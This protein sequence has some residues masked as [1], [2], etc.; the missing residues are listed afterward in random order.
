MIIRVTIWVIGDINLLSPP[1]PP[2][3]WFKHQGAGEAVG[4][5]SVEAA[6]ASAAKGRAKGHPGYRA[7]TKMGFKV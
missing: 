7:F 4:R 2:S 6:A 1:D 3:S 5:L